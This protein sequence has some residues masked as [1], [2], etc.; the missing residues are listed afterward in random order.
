MG[1]AWTTSVSMRSSVEP[2]GASRFWVE[3]NG[4]QETFF[5]EVS[6]LNITTEVFPYK[7]GGVNSY[8]HQLPTRTTYSN[9]VL[10]RGF[11]TN[12]DFG[13]WYQNI[14]MGKKDVRTVSIRLYNIE[15]KLVSSWDVTS[16]FPVK[17]IAPET[18]AGNNAFAIETLELAHCGFKIG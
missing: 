10:K 3:V 13:K 7:E 9:I 15:S 12:A 6:G 11:T 18:K 5:T 8:V 4:I 1:M 17:Y 16:A 2:A 14:I